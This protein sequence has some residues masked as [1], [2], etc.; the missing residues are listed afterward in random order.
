[1]ERTFDQ[2]AED[3]SRHRFA[4][5]YPYLCDDARWNLV[6]DKQIVGKEDIVHVCEQSSDY[7][8]S[9]RTTFNRFKTVIGERCVVSTARPS[10]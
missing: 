6:G 1:M 3:F 2:I 9:V 4:E 7:L 8:T 10:M 5:T